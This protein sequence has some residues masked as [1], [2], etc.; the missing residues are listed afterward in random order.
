[1]ITEI[2]VLI[3]IC[4]LACI[5]VIYALRN[6]EKFNLLKKDFEHPVFLFFI[7][8]III[9]S[10]WGLSNDNPHIKDA[11]IKAIIAFITA[12][13]AHLNMVFLVFFIVMIFGYFTFQGSIG[14]P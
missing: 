12:Y 13:L 6:E 14:L 5:A 8:A 4:I 9:I 3:L 10:I 1:M 11:T 7:V 2:Q